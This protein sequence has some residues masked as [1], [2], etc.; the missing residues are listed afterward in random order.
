VVADNATY[1]DAMSTA[2]AVM[3]PF[4]GTDFLDSMHIHGII[5]Y[6]ENGTLKRVTNK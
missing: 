4:A 2:I 1:A 3:G 5:Y 6:E